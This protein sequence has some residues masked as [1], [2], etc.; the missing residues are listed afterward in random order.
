VS[1][2][3]LS[4]IPVI[5]VDQAFP[6][7]TSDGR[8]GSSSSG[9]GDG[10]VTPAVEGALRD[11]LG[12]R[13]RAQDTSAF[14]AA[15]TASFPLS[16]LEGHV[17]AT[18]SPRGF[19]MQAD[20]GAVSGGQASLYNRAVS[21][22]TQMLTLLDGLTALRPDADTENCE[23]FRRLVRDA[24]ITLV[25]EMGTPGGPR[26]AVVDAF[27]RQLLGVSPSKVPADTNADT[28][29]GQLGALRVQFGFEAAFVN[30]A[31]QEG[32]RTA[33]WTLVDLALDIS[34]AWVSQ[35][36]QFTG[37]NQ[38]GFLGTQL[39]LINQLLSA[40]AEQIDEVEAALDSV[41]VSAAERQTIRLRGAQ[42]LTL[43]GLLSWTRSFV[44]D[45]GPRIARDAGRD[46]MRTSFT[47]TVLDIVAQ[48]TA[49]LRAIGRP[50]VAVPPAFHAV[51]PSAPG[52]V[53]IPLITLYPQTRM[54]PG[55]QA[56]RTQISISALDS[57]LW[58]LAKIAMRTSGYSDVV[59]FDAVVASDDVNQEILVA[60]R[61]LNISE[62]LVPVFRSRVVPVHDS[63]QRKEVR[64]KEDRTSSDDDT[65]SAVFSQV[66]LGQWLSAYDA[67][68]PA[69]PSAVQLMGLT[70]RA[71]GGRV[72]VL[73][74]SALPIALRDTLTGKRVRGLQ[75]RP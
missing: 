15:L 33:F 40:A 1:D 4:P 19:A 64:P 53:Q 9:G 23:A 71:V 36:S 20:L 28:V 44:T 65:I 47:P 42:G 22:R 50:T 27:L 75:T 72:R 12:W 45:E 57:L 68:H 17:V 34:R 13:P 70:G 56:A 8:R 41:Y 18:Y 69:S 60:V 37:K 59:L 55:M 32:I 52:A 48:I 66:A 35:R 74:A 10:S 24:I 38:N 67:A 14:T 29:S 51:V 46:G 61:G 16:E 63:S 26:V 62:S 2:D 6:P 7:P 21:A 54:P 73:P 3:E 49:L 11:V 5:D 43:D 39:V 25:S 31:D 58:R 30:N